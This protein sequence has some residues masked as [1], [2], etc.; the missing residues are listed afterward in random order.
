MV[1]YIISDNKPYM[2][3]LANNLGLDNENE[4][5]D[6]FTFNTATYKYGYIQLY[7]EIWKHYYEHP[8]A[9]FIINA[10]LKF[11]K[12]FKEGKRYNG[13]ECALAV[14]LMNKFRN[15]NNIFIFGFS[16]QDIIEEKIDFKFDDYGFIYHQ[17]PLSLSTDIRSIKSNSESPCKIISSSELPEYHIIGLLDDYYSKFYKDLEKDLNQNIGANENTKYQ[18]LSYPY[19][20]D[21]SFN[22]NFKG[23]RKWL[24]YHEVLDM[25]LLD[26]NYHVKDSK[27]KDLPNNDGYIDEV[28]KRGLD[29][30]QHIE[31][32]GYSTPIAI[33]SVS[34]DV[35]EIKEITLDYHKLIVEFIPV[36]SEKDRHSKINITNS[37][38]VI[39]YI[40]DTLKKIGSKRNKIGIL[41]THGT[42]TMAWTFSLLQ[43]SLKGLKY[44]VILTGSQ[45]PLKAEFSPSDAPAN[46]ISALYHL[47]QFVPPQI[48]VSFG[49]GKKMFDNNLKKV[50]IWNEDAFEGKVGARFNWQDI[51]TEQK[52][53]R[54]HNTLDKLLLLTTGGTIAMSS[55]PGSTGRPDPGVMTRFFEHPASK[56]RV[57]DD[58]YFPFFKEI[59]STEIDN[60]DS[61]EMNPEV[62]KKILD[63]FIKLNKEY[64]IL[65]EV[66]KKF[67]WDVYPIICSPYM[68]EKD[69]QVFKQYCYKQDGDGNLIIDKDS[70]VICKETPVVFILMG[71]GAGNIPFKRKITEDEKNIKMDEKDKIIKIKKEELNR[72]IK[73]GDVNF[74]ENYSP[75]NFVRDVIKDKN[76]V[77]LTSHIQLETPD[78]D[79]DVSVKYIEE[80]VLF[81]G[82]M[83]FAELMVKCAYLLGHIE[84]KSENKIRFLKSSIMAGVGFRTKTSRMKYIK[85]LN[86]LLENIE[87]KII[88]KNDTDIKE[89]YAKAK[90][91]YNYLLPEKNY[92]IKQSWE[93][94]ESEIKKLINP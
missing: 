26:L 49:M 53:L 72:K 58:K 45:I 83:P 66:D 90:E 19:S 88:E 29:I 50:R 55:R 10:E 84:D 73:E 28:E 76:V 4:G 20:L 18:L 3:E 24:L 70:K 23:I 7:S 48:G 31:S 22:D 1:Y 64:T 43:Y 67:S 93:D 77:I 21:D 17:L 59:F 14:R 78:L 51:E 12:T 62:Y 30:L 32:I 68:T 74:I 60:I 40:S 47:N 2:N 52:Q 71:Y 75:M 87:N 13:V 79:Y 16:T 34:K 85:L 38:T 42:D 6:Y 56:F 81:G 82:D 91:R 11:D 36:T 94:A 25:F 61:S 89:Y 65:D 39:D 9:V 54:F 80:G 5:T 57:P 8:N 63:T 46:I 35:K 33:L 37:N 44:N 27:L 15:E 69:Y 86:R 92:F 41:I